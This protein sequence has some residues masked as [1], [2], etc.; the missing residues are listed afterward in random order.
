VPI[1]TPL[2]AIT[3]APAQEAFREAA[4]I[5]VMSQI[6]PPEVFSEAVALARYQAPAEFIGI[7]ATSCVRGIMAPT[8]FEGISSKSVFLPKPDFDGVNADAYL[9]PVVKSYVF[10]FAESDTQMPQRATFTGVK[11]EMTG[12]KVT[13][14]DAFREIRCAIHM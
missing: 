5:A 4:C 13:G 8:E 1:T 11:A 3:I 7:E 9:E 2:P 14:F 10:N 6:V 12:L